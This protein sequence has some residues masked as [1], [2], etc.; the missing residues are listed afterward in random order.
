MQTIKKNIKTFQKKLFTNIKNLDS[1]VKEES[2]VF[3]YDDLSDILYFSSKDKEVSPDSVLVPL[4]SS[5]DSV[6]LRVS[7]KGEIECIVVEDFKNVFL[8]FN[9]EF[10]PLLEVIESRKT[11]KQESQIK[12]FYKSLFFGT[13]LIPVEQFS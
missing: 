2:W 6:S 12:L 11:N 1:I 13:C 10:K 5:Q 3:N 9:P 8:S 7:I 4:G